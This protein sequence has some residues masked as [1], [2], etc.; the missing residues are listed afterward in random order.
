MIDKRLSWHSQIFK[1]LR[2]SASV[3]L[4][5]KGLFCFGSV[6]HDLLH[7]GMGGGGDY[8]K[9]PRGGTCSKDTFEGYVF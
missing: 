8:N 6:N 4:F 5:K 1:I 2:H 3:E 7:S 9:I